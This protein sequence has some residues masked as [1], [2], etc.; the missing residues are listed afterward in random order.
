VNGGFDRLLKM[1]GTAEPETKPAV[2][3][4]LERSAKAGTPMPQVYLTGLLAHC[5]GSVDVRGNPSGAEAAYGFVLRGH[6]GSL[7]GHGWLTLAEGWGPV[8][9][10]HGTT[11][12]VGEYWAVIAALEKVAELGYQDIQ[13]EVRSDSQLIIRQINGEYAVTKPHL[14]ALWQKVADLRTG[15]LKVKFVWVPREQNKYADELAGRT[16]KEKR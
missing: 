13:L 5:D 12:N 15:F 8:P 16:W 9:K 7:D 4:D 14:R 10:E 1:N 3:E 2:R 11:T 6:V